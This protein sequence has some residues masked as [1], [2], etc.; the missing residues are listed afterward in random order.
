MRTT[1]DI[2][3]KLKLSTSASL[4][5]YIATHNATRNRVIND[6]ILTYL[7]LQNLHR[8]F[9]Q[10]QELGCDIEQFRADYCQYDLGALT[11]LMQND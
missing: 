11:W 6:A 1:K 5:R 7:N 8:Q 4:D 2:H 3:L 9:L 10:Y